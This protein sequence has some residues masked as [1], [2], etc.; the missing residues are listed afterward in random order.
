VPSEQSRMRISPQVSGASVV[1]LGHFNPLIFG[2][3]WL[4]DK[5]IVVGNDLEKLKTLILHADIASYELPWGN[6]QA[7]R[8]NFSVSASR[9]PPVR[10][11]DFFVRCFQFLP[12]TP[13]RAV[14]I[15]REVHFE[16]ASEAARDHVGDVLAP[17]AFWGDFVQSGG[18][19]T[20]GLRSLVMEQSVRKEGRLGRTDGRFGY[21]WAKVEPTL[22]SRYSIWGFRADK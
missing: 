12:E 15:N 1:A 17:K 13:I 18:E 4:K 22:P 2:K 19:K 5:E 7:D 16:T 11:Y 6:F 10:A 21:V 8:D 9:E 20:G 3:D 14:G